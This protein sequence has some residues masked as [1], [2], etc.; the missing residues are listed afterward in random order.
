MEITVRE[1]VLPGVGQR[2]EMDLGHGR[3]LVL[4]AAREGGRTI[5]V[6]TEGHDG[7]EGACTLTADQA[8]MAGA[9]LLGARF[10]V[11]AAPPHPGP[12]G[13]V[14]VET[15][16]VPADAPSI[17]RQ[18][19]EVVAPFGDDVVI[20]GIIRDVTPEVVEADPDPPLA[21]G[22]RVALAARSDLMPQASKLLTG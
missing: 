16:R 14:T 5:G 18:P 20:L 9:L 3:R 11:E 19:S 17:G 12:E 7:L 15:V 4:V 22:D 10:A 13:H 6:A 2:Y 1:Q 8:F 21:A